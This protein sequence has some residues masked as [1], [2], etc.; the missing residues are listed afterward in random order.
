MKTI[1]LL[2]IVLLIGVITTSVEAR[3]Q[4]T[5]EDQKKTQ[6]EADKK[7]KRDEQKAKKAAKS[8]RSERTYY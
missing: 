8:F 1:R 2:S 5:K 6:K 7:A 4:Q 3:P